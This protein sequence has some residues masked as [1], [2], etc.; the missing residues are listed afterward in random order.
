MIVAN[1]WKLQKKVGSGAFGEIYKGIH[2]SSGE[3][4][5]VKLEP[6]KTKF[7]QLYYEA[8]LY[9]IYNGAGKYDLI[10]FIHFCFS[11]SSKDLLFW[12]TR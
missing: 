9:K 7:P 8:K 2:V 6:A 10:I 5:A 3:E 12:F 4:V 1:K 11:G